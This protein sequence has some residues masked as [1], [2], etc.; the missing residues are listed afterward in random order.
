MRSKGLTLIE[1]VIALAIWGV[2]SV[3]VFFLWHHTSGS[4]VNALER[5][6]A[7]ERARGAM[8]AIAMN[9]QMASH[10]TLNTGADGRMQSLTI[11]ARNP[12]GNLHDYIFT[13]VGDTLRI[14]GNEFA[15]NIAGVYLVY[16]TGKRLDIMVVTG[17]DEPIVLNGSVCVRYKV[18]VD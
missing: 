1:L 16:V 14:G 4:T 5:Q 10:V 3:G 11:R 13:H 15:S 12:Q 6:S 9:V 8:D 2:I 17:C 18:V 7:F